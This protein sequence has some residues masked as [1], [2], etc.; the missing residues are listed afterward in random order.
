MQ[1]KL[2]PVFVHRYRLK[3][4]WMIFIVYRTVKYKDGVILLLG[5][6]TPNGLDVGR[7]FTII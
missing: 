2:L 4:W 3:P 6:T 1:R 5:A 7:N